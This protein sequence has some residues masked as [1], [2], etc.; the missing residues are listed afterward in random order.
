MSQIP[1]VEHQIPMITMEIATIVAKLTPPSPM[2]DVSANLT[3]VRA[4]LMATHPDFVAIPAQSPPFMHFHPPL[5]HGAVRSDR[6][7]VELVASRQEEHGGHAEGYAS[8]RFLSV[9]SES[10]VQPNHARKTQG[11]ALR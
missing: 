5:A 4:K 2:P 8:H 3:P 6:L 7:G 1:P 10:S 9:I 11:R